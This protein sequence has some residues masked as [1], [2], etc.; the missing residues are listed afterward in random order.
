VEPP[1]IIKSEQLVDPY[2]YL[3]DIYKM[4]EKVDSYFMKNTQEYLD[5]W[6]R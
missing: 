5:Y 2:P 6:K 1:L 3:M 4:K